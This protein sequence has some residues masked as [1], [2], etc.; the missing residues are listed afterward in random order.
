MTGPTGTPT[1]AQLGAAD[2]QNFRTDNVREVAP[3]QHSARDNLRAQRGPRVTGAGAR[4]AGDWRRSARRC[5]NRGVIPSRRRGCL[6]AQQHQ[7]ENL[8]I[9]LEHADYARSE[10]ERRAESLAA[11]VLVRAAWNNGPLT[12]NN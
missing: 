8:E 7:A 6:E 3:D 2:A 11:A 10:Q 12:G 9:P 5:R 4:A 1:R